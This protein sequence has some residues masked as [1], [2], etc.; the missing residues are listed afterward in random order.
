M[1]QLSRLALFFDSFQ[2]PP[3]TFE[4]RTDYS[5]ISSITPAHR[6]SMIMILANAKRHKSSFSQTRTLYIRSV[7]PASPLLSFAFA[8]P[9]SAWLFLVIHIAILGHFH[10]STSFPTSSYL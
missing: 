2:L 8:L 10:P 9:K 4:S 3:S 7:H 5:P 6:S 1:I